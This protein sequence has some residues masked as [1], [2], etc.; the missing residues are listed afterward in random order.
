MG[1]TAAVRAGERAREN[2][3]GAPGCDHVDYAGVGASK[4][5]STA[6]PRARP[7][8]EEE[9]PE[10]ESFTAGFTDILANPP[11]LLGAVSF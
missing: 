5:S 9:G 11:A 4:S 6:F 2:Y 10:P 7:E 1:W 3:A 8:K